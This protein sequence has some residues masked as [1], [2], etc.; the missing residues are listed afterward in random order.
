MTIF[1]RSAGTGACW[2]SAWRS[3]AFVVPSGMRAYSG[4]QRDFE[5]QLCRAATSVVSK[6]WLHIDA[7]RAAAPLPGARASSPHKQHK[8]TEEDWRNRD[9]RQEY[10]AAVNDMVARTS[11][12]H[13]PW[14][15]VPGNDKYFARVDVARTLCERLEAALE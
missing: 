2:S 6:F 15:I 10:R 7:G 4:D 13:A 14:T 8:I 1:D 9:K 11:T 5:E 3:F 12:A